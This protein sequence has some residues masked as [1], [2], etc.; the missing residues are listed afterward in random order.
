M[1]ENLKKPINLLVGIVAIAF[2]VRFFLGSGVGESFVTPYV[3]SGQVGTT[4]FEL[5]SSMFEILVGILSGVGAAI[6]FMLLKGAAFLIAIL[7][8]LFDK[9]SPTDETDTVGIDSDAMHE[10]LA[11][12]LLQAAVEGDK[13]LTIV[14][15]EKLA[16]KKYLTES[17][18]TVLPTN[19][20]PKA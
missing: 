15:A 9:N 4:G 11:R 5:L 6:I 12:L 14:V 19:S 13:E 1:N 18:I 20:F 8:P 10:D 16:G 2:C 3:E 7:L 17:A